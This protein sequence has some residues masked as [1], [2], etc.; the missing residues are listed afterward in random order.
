LSLILLSFMSATSLAFYDA[1]EVRDLGHHSAH[2]RC[3]L[4]RRAPSDLVKPKPDERPALRRR[5]PDRAAGLLDGD[6]FACHGTLQGHA[7]ATSASA[8]PIWRRA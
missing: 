4:K 3:V 1:D 8:P 6:G 2:G 5:A 7:S